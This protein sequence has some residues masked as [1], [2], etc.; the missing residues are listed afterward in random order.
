MCGKLHAMVWWMKMRRQEKKYIFLVNW[1]KER[2]A[3]GEL[4]PGDR[5]HSENELSAMFGMSRQTVRNAIGV[6]ESEGLVERIQGSGTYIGAGRKTVREKTRNI[7]VITTYMDG[8]IF[9]A[10]LQSM[11]QR[12]AA[13]GYRA[14][15]MFTNNQV[16][17]ERKI[18][19]S[20]LKKDNVDGVIV[21]AS[22]SAFFNPNLEYY[23]QLRE[24]QVRILFFNCR[25][26]ELDMPLVAL[27]D[28]AVS[29]DL[30]RYLL[31]QG[32][33][34]IGGIFKLDDGQ[35]KLRY[36]GY[37]KAL[38]D[39]GIRPDDRKIVWI[40]T[41]DQKNLK[42]MKDVIFG[43]LSDCTAVF[44][45]NDEVAFSF[46][47][48]LQEKNIQ[49]PGELSVVSI[50]GSELSLLAKPPIT[51]VP[52]P[53]EA[54]G[55]KAAENILRMIEQPNFKGDFMYRPEIQVRDSV[56]KLTGGGMEKTGD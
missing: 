14:Q 11:V 44:C 8:Y 26:P 4:K 32:H 5:I 45:Y 3:S 55:R 12:L 15:I 10:T 46:M 27:D 28:A 29:E 9:P 22:Q 40:D 34:K 6:L 23:R 33:R 7:V 13:A 54:L 52:Y 19:Q 39:A 2:I 42:G 18:L 17:N 49:V 1:I 20:L 41:E 31:D 48:L 43:K 36:G 30:V 25:Y 50:D 37:V 47:E 24:R 35:G 56:R 38:L 51:S 16:D 21:E 53:M